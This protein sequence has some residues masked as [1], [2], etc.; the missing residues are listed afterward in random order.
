M[1]YS[2]NIRTA[3]AIVWFMGCYAYPIWAADAKTPEMIMAT[4][5]DETLY[6]RSFISESP[7]S[8][9]NIVKIEF[10]QIG[11]PSGANSNDSLYTFVSGACDTEPIRRF[12]ISDRIIWLSSSDLHWACETMRMPLDDLSLFDENDPKQQQRYKKRYP[13]SDPGQS[14]YWS[15]T[16]ARY[17]WEDVLG[18]WGDALSFVVPPEFIGVAFCDF[19]PTSP[20]GGLLFEV[21]EDWCRVWKATFTWGKDPRHY[22]RWTNDTPSFKP[23]ETIDAPTKTELK[24]A[25][26]RPFMVLERAGDYYFLTKEGRL[27]VSAK[28]AK[29]NDI[30]RQTEVFWFDDDNPIFALISDANTG[31]QFAFTK[32][33]AKKESAKPVCFEIVGDKKEPF[34]VDAAL[35]KGIEAKAPLKQARLLAQILID[36]KK[37]EPKPP[38]KK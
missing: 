12:R 33:A 16:K 8:F 10:V 30:P 28:R 5:I 7:E 14:H 11:S 34:P 25:Y 13:D 29:K 22:S 4:I 20:T 26:L 27:F 36:A 17:L 31:R 2:N 19:L 18:I 3:L 38:A 15:F 6:T 9:G 21:R 1:S 24:K 37:I 23:V 35:L 32:P